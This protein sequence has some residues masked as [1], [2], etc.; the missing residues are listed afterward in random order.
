MKFKSLDEIKYDRFIA[1]IHIDDEDGSWVVIDAPNKESAVDFLMDEMKKQHPNAKYIRV[2][3]D[4]V[5][6]T[7]GSINDLYEDTDYDE[8]ST[9]TQKYSSANTSINSSKLP[10][11]FNLVRFEPSTINLDYGG[12]KFDNATNMLA[13]NGVTNLIYDPF[14]RSTEHNSY[15]LSTVKKNGG[16]DT[17]T[18]SNVL[19]VIA[20]EN[21]R[22]AVITNIYKLLKSNGVAYFTVYE[23]DGMGTG[24]E[25]SAGYQLN[26]KTN[27]Y[28]EDI[29][30]IFPNVQRKGKLI[31]A[32][33]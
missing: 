33:K 8:V 16:A 4:E 14:N 32:K 21:V 24:R 5:T 12:G 27:E 10:A 30:K 9:P 20:E 13:Q 26:K 6:K 23:G 18:C 15:V 28:V 2:S 1:I 3:I 31:I 19:N 11:I 25:T 22:A 29:S 7:F 17:A